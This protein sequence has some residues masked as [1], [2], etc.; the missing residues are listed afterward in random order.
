MPHGISYTCPH[1]L[2]T[3]GSSHGRQRHQNSEHRQFTPAP[4]GEDEHEFERRYHLL[5]N[6]EYA[7]SYFLSS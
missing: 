3:F 6:G 4:E 1:C 7:P 2:A 5:A